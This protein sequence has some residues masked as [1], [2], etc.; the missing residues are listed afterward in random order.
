MNGNFI[1]VVLIVGG[2]LA[3][4]VNL[5]LFEIDVVALMRTWWPLALIALGVALFLTPEAKNKKK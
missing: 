2:A 4:A 3:L 5:G 1:S